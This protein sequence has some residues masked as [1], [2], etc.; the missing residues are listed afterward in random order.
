MISGHL[1]LD[2]NILDLVNAYSS[3]VLASTDFY[4]SS[5]QSHEIVLQ[6]H[7]CRTQSF[8]FVLMHSAFFLSCAD[9]Q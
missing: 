5:T 6:S 8:W 9:L 3:I 4:H 2:I 7:S 1:W